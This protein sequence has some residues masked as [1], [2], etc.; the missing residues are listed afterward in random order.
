[1][2]MVGRMM[3]SIAEAPQSRRAKSSVSPAGNMGET[4]GLSFVDTM[5]GLVQPPSAL[6]PAKTAP[7]S[8]DP[9]GGAKLAPDQVID[10]AATVTDSLATPSAVVP[11]LPIAIT[12]INPASPST[13]AAAVAKQEGIGAAGQVPDAQSAAVT[14]A[15]MGNAVPAEPVPGDAPDALVAQTGDAS[16]T[17]KTG[18]ASAL[19]SASATAP[20]TQSAEP[21]LKPAIDQ[22]QTAQALAPKTQATVSQSLLAG[23]AALGQT[24]QPAADDKQMAQ[25]VATATA[26]AAATATAT[27][28]V[29]TPVMAQVPQPS[30]QP[31]DSSTS[32]AS[33]V[34]DLALA[35]DPQGPGAARA[36]EAQSGEARTSKTNVA[37]GW[38]NTGS[39]FVA[40]DDAGLQSAPSAA[41]VATATA[42][43]SVALVTG[44][45]PA[46]S[47]PAT[48]SEETKIA[49]T[50]AAGMMAG[51]NGTADAA[52]SASTD[53]TGVPAPDANPKP[54]VLQPH[55]VP[56]LA[57]AMM[58][59][60]QNGMKEFTLRL[61]PPELGR[62]DVR[63][64]VGTDKKV[65]AVVST[66]RPEALKDLALS[67][68]DLT[69]ALQEAGLEL[70]ENGLSF[71]M[72]DQGS[73]PQN[74]DANQQ[75]SA[76]IKHSLEGYDT[77]EAATPEPAAPLSAHLSG[78]VERWQRARIA[79]TA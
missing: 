64:T 4:A 50:D 52:A 48:K 22:A 16:A 36:L 11:A 9:T 77:S 28:T 19:A 66:D 27:A 73:S 21:A 62:V 57:A 53:G 42:Q 35:T 23:L 59:R 46:F 68:R 13:S 8:R 38:L 60:I 70:E 1:M 17:F 7:D 79:M 12:P 33:A 24:Q 10:D 44:P 65:R 76:R 5:I 31:T 34:F 25:L 72:N 20:S 14:L 49:A 41:P 78:P 18:D 71:S 45:V 30:P 51:S 75:Q 29:P 15:L 54:T 37:T 58:R 67:A 6:E 61:D 40:S 63:L 74:R 55:T 69:R 43:A 56:M 47:K 3:D 32:Q 26:T 39:G 2:E